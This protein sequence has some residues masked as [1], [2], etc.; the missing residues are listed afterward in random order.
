MGDNMVLLCIGDS[1]TFGYGVLKNERFINI[2]KGKGIKVIN[3][4]INGDT[5]SGMLSRISQDLTKAASKEAMTVLTL[6]GIND[7]FQGRDVDYVYKNICLMGTE[8]IQKG[9]NLILGIESIVIAEKA[10]INWDSSLN[11][12]EINMKMKELRKLL[13]D[14]G[15]VTADFYKVLASDCSLFHEDGV[16][17]NKKGHEIIAKELLNIIK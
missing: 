14:S 9:Y 17:P 5:T 13:L 7:F 8:V 11:Y 1:I 12:D 3:R 6:G 10:L 16:H 4:G 2:I 15:Y